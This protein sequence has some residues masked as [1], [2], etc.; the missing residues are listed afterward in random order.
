MIVWIII[1]FNQPNI[2]LHLHKVMKYDHV[3]RNIKIGSNSDDQ[4]SPVENH[5]CV[6]VAVQSPRIPLRAA[7]LDSIRGVLSTYSN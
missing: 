3:Y 7:Y 2:K 4:S 5:R 1:I 6:H